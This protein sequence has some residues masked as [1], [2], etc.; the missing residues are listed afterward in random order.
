VIELI[1][2]NILKVKLPI[3]INLGFACFKFKYLSLKF[4]QKAGMY[5]DNLYD[6][7]YNFGN[8]LI[9]YMAIVHKC[10]VCIYI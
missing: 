8:I 7:N 1:C 3:H 4:R 6:N 5:R 2:A 10:C 9:H